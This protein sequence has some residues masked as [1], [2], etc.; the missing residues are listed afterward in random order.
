[1]AINADQLAAG[2][3]IAHSCFTQGRFQDSEI[4]LEGLITIQPDNPYLHL[5]LGSV[6]LQQ[7]RLDESVIS[8]DRVIEICPEN[9]SALTNRGEIHLKQGRLKEAAA[10]LER[11]SAL[12]EKG[13]DP[14]ANRAR[15]L[16]EMT[17]SLLKVAEENGIAAVEHARQQILL[18]FKQN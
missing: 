16:I 3:T 9:T 13:E 15:L 14:F 12:D 4:L 1:M 5:L 6:L 18:Q 11:A 10:D 2:I 7:G 8:F 17:A